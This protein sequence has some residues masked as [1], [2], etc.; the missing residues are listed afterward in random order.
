MKRIITC[1]PIAITSAT[2][3]ICLV[4]VVDI[5]TTPIGVQVTRL[6]GIVLVD[7]GAFAAAVFATLVFALLTVVLYQ[8]TKEALIA[9]R[10]LFN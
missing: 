5:L 4:A 2:S 10:H 9:K 6:L 7:Y 1:I 3:I 8:P